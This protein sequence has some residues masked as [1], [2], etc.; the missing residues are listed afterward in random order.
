MRK[1]QLKDYLLAPIFLYKEKKKFPSDA[2][3][4]T[5]RQITKDSEHFKLVR[6]VLYRATPE[7]LRLAIPVSQ[8]KMMIW[9]AHDSLMSLHQGRTKTVRKL[10]T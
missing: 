6:G 8:R 3:K 9:S 2:K 4:G 5:I 7:G 1:E 10:Q